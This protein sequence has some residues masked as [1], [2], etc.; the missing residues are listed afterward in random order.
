MLYFLMI[1]GDFFFIF[2]RLQRWRGC[3]SDGA[4]ELLCGRSHSRGRCG[5]EERSAKYLVDVLAFGIVVV[6]VFDVAIGVS[7]RQ[8]VRV[9]ANWRCSN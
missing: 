4:F 6:V 5:R 7:T 3:D 8:R 9:R 2:F 1:D